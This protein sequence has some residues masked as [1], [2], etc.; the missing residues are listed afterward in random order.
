M[1]ALEQENLT[2]RQALKELA[3]AVSARR[4]ANTEETR[5]WLDEAL[6]AAWDVLR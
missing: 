4:T 5:R 6:Q 3:S 1:P 2:L